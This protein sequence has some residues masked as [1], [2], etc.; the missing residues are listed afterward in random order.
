MSASP[1]MPL[2]ISGRRIIN[3]AVNVTGATTVVAGQ[4]WP[5][6]RITYEQR[7]HAKVSVSEMQPA[8]ERERFTDRVGLGACTERRA[9]V[10]GSMAAAKAAIIPPPNAIRIVSGPTMRWPP[11]ANAAAMYPGIVR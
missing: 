5:R 6:E 8:C 9:V 1:T 10:A 2:R 4:A 7:P 11:I 3:P